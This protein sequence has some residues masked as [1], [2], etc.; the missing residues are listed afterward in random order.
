MAIIHSLKCTVPFSFA[1]PLFSLAATHC[2]SLSL[3]ATHFHSLSLFVPLVVIRCHSLYHSLSFVVTRCITRCATRCHSLSLDV[4]LVCLFISD[5][6]KLT[7]QHHLHKMYMAFYLLK[8]TYFNDV[9]MG[10]N[11]LINS[12]LER[13]LFM[14]SMKQNWEREKKHGKRKQHRWEWLHIKLDTRFKFIESFWIWT[15]NKNQRYQ[16]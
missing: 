2:H 12:Q 13:T 16:Q 3:F 8:W 11:I 9:N 14:S 7:F 4:P 5:L 1:V 10:R 6:S 15:K